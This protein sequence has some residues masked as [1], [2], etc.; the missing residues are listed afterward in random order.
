LANTRQQESNKEKTN[1]S[2]QT[3]FQT[4]NQHQNTP[5]T[6]TLIAKTDLKSNKSTEQNYLNRFYEQ[7]SDLN[8]DRRLQLAAGG[9]KLVEQQ[10]TAAK[11]SPEQIE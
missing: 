6:E 3:I 10:Q 1:N 2:N 8:G 5:K 4:I 9:V 11:S 7:I